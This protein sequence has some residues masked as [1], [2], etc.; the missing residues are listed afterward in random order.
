MIAS[1]AGRAPREGLR[2]RLQCPLRLRIV[3][4]LA[5]GRQRTTEQ[6]SD[7]DEREGRRDRPGGDH[8]PGMPGA[9]ERDGLRR[10][11]HLIPLLELRCN[12]G[13]LEL[14]R[15]VSAA[16]APTSTSGGPIQMAG[17][18]SS[19]IVTT[20]S[21][22]LRK[23]R[24]S[25]RRSRS[26]RRAVSPTALRAVQ[27]SRHDVDEHAEREELGDAAPGRRAVD[28][29]SSTSWPKPQPQPRREGPRRR[30]PRRTRHRRLQPARSAV[31]ISL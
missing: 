12:F 31:I 9:G 20:T 19:R 28:S 11:S 23:K 21:L 13:R 15:D 14:T 10:D 22:P 16:T 8:A 29:T 1:L 27:C 24:A 3:R 26:P 6:G 7:R 18:S 30:S 5:L 25:S 17:T 2:P 4:R